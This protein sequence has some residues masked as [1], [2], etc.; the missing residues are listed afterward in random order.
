MKPLYIFL[1]EAIP[2]R[3]ELNPLVDRYA[4]FNCAGDVRCQVFPAGLGCGHTLLVDLADDWQNL[5]QPYMQ[6]HRIWVAML[7]PLRHLAVLRNELARSNLHGPYS[8]ML[9]D[10]EAFPGGK[11]AAGYLRE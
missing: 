3:V 9:V 1:L 11:K 10:Q 7:Y 5:L 2:E 8:H 6:S 4:T